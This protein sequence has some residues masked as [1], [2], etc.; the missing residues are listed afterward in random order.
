MEN[1]GFIR[2]AA[3][4]NARFGSLREICDHIVKTEPRHDPA[5]YPVQDL[6]EA[7]TGDASSDDG[8]TMDVA[9]GPCA[10]ATYRELYLSG[11][12][13]PLDVARAILPLIRR[14]T[15]P[16][17]EHS[18]AWI[19]VRPDLILEAAAASTR[20]Y[21]EGRSLGPL[22]GVPTAVKDD[23]D[24]EGYKTSLGTCHN[25]APDV[26]TSDEVCWCIRKLEEM[27]A[28]NLGKLSLHEFGMDT[29]GYNIVHGT[30]RNPHDPSYY[31]GG[32]STGSAYAVASG[33]V[34]LSLGADG[35]GSIRLPASFCSVFG[36]KPTHGRVS[37]YPGQNLSGTAAVRGP[38]AAD[39]RS[40]IA[41]YEVASAPDPRSDFPPSPPFRFSGDG[42]ARPKI[43][44]LPEAWFSRAEPSV[45]KLCRALIARLV[46][47]KGYA[48][49][50][51]DIP[52]VA[53]GQIA[54]AITLLADAASLLQDMTGISPANRILFALGR[55]TPAWDYLLAQKLRR[56]LMQHLAW[57]WE[58]H[59]GMILV[60]P[61][62]ASAGWPIRKERELKY[63]VSDG[64]QTMKTME[65]VWMGNF[66]GVPSITVPAGFAPAEGKDA[67]AP[68]TV[69]VGLMGTGEWCSEE[70]L[71]RFG[72][73]AE[74][75]GADLQRRPPNYV[76]VIALAKAQRA[77]EQRGEVG[78]DAGSTSPILPQAA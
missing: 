6:P 1:V 2:K 72:L 57:L 20:R 21:A 22:D 5:V 33:L 64:D 73:D 71:L 49:V 29:A 75:V 23:Y 51:V 36:L 77:R 69:P 54:H 62:S 74:E 42:A 3:W 8:T 40:L 70:S 38:L 12:L 24:M 34:P 41:M 7:S 17:G 32:S 15:T 10:A 66:C 31:P 11:E 9:P 16:P 39:M 60:T 25:Y 65:Y 50:P 52:L 14:D 45:Q 28:V 78:D 43:L 53:E 35:G 55:T 67:E 68:A 27:G 76:D 46:K 26:V 48:V 59:P 30:P 18:V 63:G 37:F 58:Q 56:V 61:T 4:K 19:E 13:T 47:E 44:G